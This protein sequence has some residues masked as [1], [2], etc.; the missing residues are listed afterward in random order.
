[1]LLDRLR[2][3]VAR[4]L[5]SFINAPQKDYVPFAITDMRKLARVLEPGDVVLVEGDRRVSVAIKYLT[6]STWSHA[7]LFVG[8]EFEVT[9]P[10]QNRRRGDAERVLVEADVE[11]GVR[12]V[13]LNTYEG[14]N[15]RVCR[16][17]GL[18]D[19]DRKKLIRLCLERLG[20]QYDLDNIADLAR[21]LFPM[22]PVP[23]RLRRR[24]LA[25]G[26]GDP[27]R[28][29]CSTLLA[30]AF[31]E[32]IRYPILPVVEKRPFAA[33]HDFHSYAGAGANFSNMEREVLHVRQYNL[34]VPRDFDVSPYFKIIK[35]TL[36]I[37]FDYRKL[38]WADDDDKR[39]Q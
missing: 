15:V 33:D 32:G 35:P 23:Q 29:I 20:D 3:F 31:E 6:Q 1:M 2:G 36:E 39:R 21:Y 10:E 30:R 14:L 25:I 37:G 19:H 4:S 5:A 17:V 28:A 12:V 26:A 22:P 27:T 24:M 16:P 18:T 11:E 9:Q 7:A 8:D 38:R 34:Y 13:P